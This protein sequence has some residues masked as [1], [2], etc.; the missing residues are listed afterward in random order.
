M[1]LPFHILRKLLFTLIYPFVT[2]GI[3]IWGHSPSAQLKRLSNK[4]D[5]SVKLLGNDRVLSVSYQKRN[6]LPLAKICQVFTLIRVF[7]YYHL[8]HSGH[9]HELFG[10]QE[11]SHN[12]ITRFNRNN[13]LNIP[14][15]YSSKYRCSFYVNGIKLWK[16]LPN[17]LKNS[18]SIFS[19]KKNLRRHLGNSLLSD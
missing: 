5:K 15:I 12:H 14:M 19:L 1:I 4:I 13:N 17:V 2:Y 3:E 10:C 7:K 18:H 8:H 11:V 6:T 9:F 16:K